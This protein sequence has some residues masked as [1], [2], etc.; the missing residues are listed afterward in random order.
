MERNYMGK[1]KR[2]SNFETLE[3]IKRWPKL[4]DRF[5]KVRI[6]SAEW[7]AYWRGK[8]N[9]YTEDPRESHVWDI[10][11]AF[12]KTSHC[13]PEKKIQFIEAKEIEYNICGTCGAKDGRAGD[14]INGECLNCFYTRKTGEVCIHAWLKRTDEEIQ[15]TMDI[16]ND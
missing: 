16:L 1:Y 15:K 7:T 6:Y 11:E 12:E 8:G 4:M 13:G 14:L 9:G 3:R 5:P 10:K 2:Y